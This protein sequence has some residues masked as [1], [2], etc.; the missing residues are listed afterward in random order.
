MVNGWSDPRLLTI[1]GLRNRGYTP[2]AIKNFIDQINVARS[3]NENV[4][5]HNVLEIELKKELYKNCERTMAVLEPK[6]M[7]ILNME[8][9]WIDIP[10]F[11]ENV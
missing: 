5:R 3:G 4:I 6:V 1:S 8:E 9:E 11:P 7:R 10:L 2:E